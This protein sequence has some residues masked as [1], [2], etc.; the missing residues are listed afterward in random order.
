MKMQIA[1][2]DATN[3]A[4]VHEEYRSSA[5]NLLSYLALRRN[6]SGSCKHNSVSVACNHWHANAAPPRQ[7]TR[8]DEGV[9]GS[10]F[11]KTVTLE[12]ERSATLVSLFSSENRDVIR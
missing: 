10:F 9:A 2:G 8:H 5:V 1:A 4:N 3:F 12:P 6:E 7:K 11:A